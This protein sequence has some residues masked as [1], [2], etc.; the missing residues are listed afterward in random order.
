M[1]NVEVTPEVVEA[2]IVEQAVTPENAEPNNG[3]VETPTVKT[4]TQDEVNEMITKRLERADQT[5]VKKAAQEARDAV[6]ADMGYAWNGQ[7]IKTESEYK[8]AVADQKKYEDMQKQGMPQEAIDRILAVER[9]QEETTAKL[10][11]YESKS[12]QAQD[13][14]QFLEAYPDVK[15]EDIPASVWQEVDKGKSLVDAYARHEN[16]TLKQQIAEIT[17]AKEIEALNAQNAASSTGSVT[18]QGSAPTTTFYTQKQ[19]AQ[20][21]LEETNRNWSAIQQS[22]KNPKFYD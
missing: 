14:Q 9:A 20:M 19:V 8:R 16:L 15:A 17:K 18:G 6:I 2:P 12:K 3:T 10:T 22:M 1:E 13:A 5:A 21:S 11:E 4:F 7:P